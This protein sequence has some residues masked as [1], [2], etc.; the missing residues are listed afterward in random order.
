MPRL[1]QYEFEYEGSDNEAD[2]VDVENDYYTAKCAYRADST[3]QDLARLTR[4]PRP[5]FRSP[6][7]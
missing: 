5:C 3:A 2:V 1:A 4:V 7:G 6:L